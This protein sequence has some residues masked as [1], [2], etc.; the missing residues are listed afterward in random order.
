M[1]VGCDGEPIDR[2]EFLAGVASASAGMAI[3]QESEPAEQKPSD[4]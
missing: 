4:A 3:T 1:C 2:R